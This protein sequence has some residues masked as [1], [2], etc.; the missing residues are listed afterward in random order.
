MQKEPPPHLRVV[1]LESNF[2]GDLVLDLKAKEAAAA[3]EES[4]QDYFSG[5]AADDEEA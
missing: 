3:P 2:P 4:S 1:F 5:A